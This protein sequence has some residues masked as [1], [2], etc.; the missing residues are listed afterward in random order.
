MTGREDYGIKND[1]IAWTKEYN[2]S[3]LLRCNDEEISKA[4]TVQFRYNG[5]RI[6]RHLFLFF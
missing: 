5:R 3:L 6:E 2:R 1:K 4:K